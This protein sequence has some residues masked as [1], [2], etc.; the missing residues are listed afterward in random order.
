MQDGIDGNVRSLGYLKHLAEL[1]PGDDACECCKWAVEEIEQ[2]R[3][4]RAQLRAANGHLKQELA[5]RPQR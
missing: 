1:V 5:M 2:L 4:K 3:V